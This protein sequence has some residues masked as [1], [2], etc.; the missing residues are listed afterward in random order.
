MVTRSL[1]AASF[2][3]R[4]LP[5]ARLGGTD[6]L[7]FASRRVLRNDLLGGNIS[8]SKEC[9]PQNQEIKDDDHH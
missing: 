9:F 3:G 8:V 2:E 7:G 4:N 5:S 1:V 6:Q